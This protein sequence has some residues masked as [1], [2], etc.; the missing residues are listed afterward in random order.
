VEPS[1]LLRERAKALVD[2]LSNWSD[3][4]A[5]ELFAD[6]VESDESFDRRADDARCRTGGEPIVLLG[7]R[8]ANRTTGT[9]MIS[10][11]TRTLAIEFSLSPARALIQE[12]SWK[13]A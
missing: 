3:Q 12:Y 7:V 9:A 4:A 8:A 5:R 6:N 1:A 13:E 2:L 11:G 10:V